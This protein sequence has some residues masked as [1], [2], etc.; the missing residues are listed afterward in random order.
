M[1]GRLLD[2]LP[3]LAPSRAA[4]GGL[5]ELRLPAA[6]LQLLALVEGTHLDAGHGLAQFL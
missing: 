3:P 6:G 4:T 1:K 2:C 5:I